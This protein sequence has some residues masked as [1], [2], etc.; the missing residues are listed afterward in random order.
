MTD[1]QL[2]LL[3]GVL[4][5]AASI[6]YMTAG[7]R[8]PWSFILPFRGEKLLA[9][10][11][12]ALAVSTSTVLFQTISFN[13]ILTPSIMGFD[14]LYLLL[15]TLG[16]YFLGGVGFSALSSILVF[17]ITTLSL[18][19][20][21]MALFGTL[22]GQ[23]RADLLRMILTGIIFGVLFHSLTNFVQ[24]MIDPNEF[25]TIQLNSFARFNTIETDVLVIAAPVT[26]AALALAWRM[27]RR[28]DV[29]ALGTDTAISLGERPKLGQ[30]Q[31]LALIAVLVSVSTAFVGP[32]A[33]L[34]L[35]VVSVAH[36]I[37][38]TPYHAT[39]MPI[40]G[41]ISIVTLVGGQTVL[42]RVLGL[43]TPLS[44]ATDLIGGIV[45]L[46]LMLK[47]ARR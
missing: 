46:L 43:T 25:A 26:L 24:R 13:R 21:A 39:L 17:S 4:A 37:R 33:F 7:A 29:I 31:A 45:F 27:R 47:G 30:L 14:A 3:L 11:L 15:L 18:I 1:R 2:I 6:A 5:C 38:P 19:I 32:V 28:L 22:L 41:L 10:I 42:E 35:L 40:A 34:G 12:V 44:V 23:A 8:A 20:A 36:A 16:V 9:L